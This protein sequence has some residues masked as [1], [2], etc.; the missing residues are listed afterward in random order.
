MT[1]PTP[2]GVS[3]RRPTRGARSRKLLYVGCSNARQQRSRP[4]SPVIRPDA[5]G[6]LLVLRH[7]QRDRLLVRR[8]AARALPARR[9]G[10]SSPQRRA[11]SRGPT[12]AQLDPPAEAA[13]ELGLE[14]AEL[15]R[16]S[17][18]YET[19]ARE[20]SNAIS[21]EIGFTSSSSV[22][23]S[24]RKT[25]IALLGLDAVLRGLLAVD[26]GRP[27]DDLA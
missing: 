6:E 12:D 20:P 22:R 10:P 24:S 14:L 27:A 11:H 7:P 25:R 2:G 21:T 23:I 3:T 18:W 13:A 8:E 19:T 4:Q 1:T 15:G 9:R 16:L 17:A 5:I 26:L